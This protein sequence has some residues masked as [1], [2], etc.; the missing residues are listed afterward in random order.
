MTVQ[1]QQKRATEARWQTDNPV[2]ADGEIGVVSPSGRIKVG[3]GVR[4]W[5]SLPYS[6][7][8]LDEVLTTAD[9]TYLTDADAAATYLP[10][11]EAT[12][13]YLSK[14]DA[15]AAY[16]TKTA[17]ATI[18]IA[19]DYF[20]DIDKTG[21]EDCL[22]ALQ[23]IID[24]ALPGDT[25]TLPAGKFLI[26]GELVIDK[27]LKLVG[28]GGRIHRTDMLDR[29]WPG[30]ASTN[31]V[32]ESATANGIRITA[33]GVIIQD[34]AVVN[35]RALLT[36]PTAGTGIIFDGST[37]WALHRVTVEGFYD[38]IRTDGVYW[39]IDSCHVYDP[40][41]Y[42]IYMTQSGLADD[43]GY[44]GDNGDAGVTNSI[45]TMWCRNA[46]A[47][48]AVRWDAGG[49][50]RWVG[51]KINGNSPATGWQYGID[52]MVSDGVSTGEMT[53]TGGAIGW[54][55]V[56]GVRVGQKGPVN[57]SNFAH[58]AISGMVFQG[59]AEPGSV[60]LLLGSLNNVREV[61]VTGCNFHNVA[62]GG[63]V[64]DG[65][66]GL[67]IGPNVWGDL[68][69]EGPLIVI[70][71]TPS[72]DIRRQNVT[73]SLSNNSSVTIIKDERS[74]GTPVPLEGSIEYNYKRNVFINADVVGSATGDF[75]VTKFTIEPHVFG[76]AGYIDL[77]FAGH[78]W[79][80]TYFAKR[81]R[82]SFLKN[83]NTTGGAISIDTVGT[84][85]AVGSTTYVGLRVI[86]A[87]S[88][89]IAVQT[90]ML[91]GGI[92]VRGVVEIDVSG[93]VQKFSLGEGL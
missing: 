63:I 13:D 86:D 76:G 81:I 44:F 17:G 83:N 70:R 54:F 88:G 30:Y 69:Y 9:D 87:G 6:A 22:E 38:N 42:G 11:T 77:T 32:S 14:A 47:T 46:R 68:E 15:A 89:K 52:M 85:E 3:D 40:V 82:R 33:P 35:R 45:L 53:L 84:D 55:A 92:A 62:P 7:P 59:I 51:N 50:L 65:V 64:A 41:R 67:T 80:V 75:W 12:E 73:Q 60:A 31:I 78:D 10:K 43:E 34:I 72:V 21:E 56:A 23:G 18:G 26:D 58:L 25:I 48:A 90:G 5:N 91:D 71:D 8:S 36:P 2:L 39:T 57:D 79:D 19:P 93:R 16:L 1:Q 27:P 49:G 61:V 74:M 37:N 29:V 20:V 24:A 4:A 66:T 28:S